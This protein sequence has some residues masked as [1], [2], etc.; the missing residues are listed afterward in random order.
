MNVALLSNLV[1]T[2]VISVSTMYSPTGKKAKRKD[3]PRWA[4]LIKYEGE[5]VYLAHGKRFLSDACH[6][7]VLPKGCS[8][9]WQCTREGH[10]CSIEFEC[11][12][13]GDEPIT[14]P[15]K[16][17]E[18]LLRLF[19]E[20]YGRTVRRYLIEKR[21]AYACELLEN[22]DMPVCSV[23]LS[24]GFSDEIHFMKSFKKQYGMT[25]TEYRKSAK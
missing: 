20:E 1:I 6:V 24:C 5:T 15:I 14:V 11:E 25:A 9:E 22:S 4:I 8:Y 19:K 23:A 7:A 18:K 17:G 21:L 3:R 10:F 16:N 12:R 13:S 2:N